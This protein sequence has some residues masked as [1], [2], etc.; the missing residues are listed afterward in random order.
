M[1]Q[2]PENQGPQKEPYNKWTLKLLKKLKKEAVKHFPKTWLHNLRQYIYNTYRNTWTEV[3]AIIK[4]LQ[5]LLFIHFRIKCQ[6]SK[7]GIV[8]QKKAKNEASKS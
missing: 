4:I 7:I 5:Q 1:E 8:R 6:H 3:K 2:T